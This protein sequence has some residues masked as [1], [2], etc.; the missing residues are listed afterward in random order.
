MALKKKKAAPKKA[1]PQKK[2]SPKAKPET[3]K[4]E[5]MTE[6]QSNAHRNNMRLLGR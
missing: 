6:K 4:V 2:A 3:V 1:V 5:K